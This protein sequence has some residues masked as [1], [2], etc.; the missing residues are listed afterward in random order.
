MNPSTLTITT[1]SNFKI[2]RKDPVDEETMIQA[3]RIIRDIRQNRSEGLRRAIRQYEGRVDDPILIERAELEAAYLRLPE[4]TR[5]VLART[6]ARIASFAQAQLDCLRPL[7]M[8]IEGG[9]AGHELRPVSRVGCY[10][11][12]G[13]YPLPSSV[14]MTAVTAKVAGVQSIIVATPSNDDIMLGAAWL[15]GA[16]HVLWSG[17][18]HAVA[19]LAYGL[20]EMD[21]VDMI[22]G[23][24]NRWVT[25]AKAL[26][27]GRVGID[28]LAGPSELVVAADET[29]DPETIA[30]DLLGQAEHDTDAVPILVTTSQG[31]AKA[32]LH[33]CEQQLAR[34]PTQRI[35][36]AALQ[37]GS[38]VLCASKEEMVDIIIHCAPEHLEI[39]CAE[40]A[41]FLRDVQHYGGAFVGT[42]SAEVFGDYGVGPN[43]VLPTGGTAR[44]TGGLSVFT[45]V[46]VRTWM[47]M[48]KPSP[49]DTYVSDA[50][51]LANCEGLIGHARSAQARV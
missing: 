6:Q 51:A 13:N 22:V 35:A 49:G 9:R 15:A 24:G 21:A 26:V 16:D 48:D 5:A 2:A 45:F 14:L 20:E 32:V 31:L 19:A 39:Q 29:G 18:A 23:P 43:H 17:G 42:A 12:G 8:S 46:R 41:R 40:P 7:D 3:A 38:V 34:L 50:I 47:E 25:A 1:A 10:A 28:M 11:P 30:A 44:Y 27:M 33:A 36:Q 37:N 4:E